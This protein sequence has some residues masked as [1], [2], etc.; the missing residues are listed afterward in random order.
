M[1]YLSFL[2]LLPALIIISCQSGQ[3]EQ[4]NTDDTREAKFRQ[5]ASRTAERLQNLYTVDTA[6]IRWTAYKT[7]EK[8]PVSGTF[9]RVEWKNLHDA[10]TPQALLDSVAFKIYTAGISTDNP[11]RDKTIYDYLFGKILYGNYIE[12][13]VTQ[14]DEKNSRLTVDM[15]FNGLKRPL[16]FSYTVSDT[17]IHAV[18]SF[19]LEKDFQ[20]GEALYFLHTACEDKHTGPDGVS[21]TWP[22]VKVEA[23][24]RYHKKDE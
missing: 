16:T 17:L 12:G 11:E 13:R 5:N 2:S 1:K 19:D 9:T 21:K 4:N 3:S 15:Y 23:F 14:R 22:D 10:E 7:T 6:Y 8:I 20:A 24:I 18:S